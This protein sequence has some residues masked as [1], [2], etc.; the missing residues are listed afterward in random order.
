MARH[1][2]FRLFLISLVIFLAGRG[3]SSYSSLIESES[4]VSAELVNS[5]GV[6]LSLIA[7]CAF[8][9]SII[10]PLRR[11]IKEKRGRLRRF[12]GIAVAKFF[13][14]IFI[15]AVFS[16][17][18]G[19]PTYTNPLCKPGESCRQIWGFVPVSVIVANLDA[20]APSMYIDWGSFLVSFLILYLVAL[21]ILY[22]YTIISE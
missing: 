4:Q 12:F 6:Y 7:V 11:K 18:H 21:I 14:I 2:W 3:L 5:A 19:V 22:V 16:I 13:V 20:V 1:P 8:L 15:I 9:I 10:M 17:I